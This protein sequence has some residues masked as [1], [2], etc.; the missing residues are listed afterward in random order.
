MVEKNCR[1]GIVVL[2]VVEVKGWL[3]FGILII[4]CVIDLVRISRRG[5]GVK[6]KVFFD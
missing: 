2:V 5:L 1:E 4:L 6:I 3:M